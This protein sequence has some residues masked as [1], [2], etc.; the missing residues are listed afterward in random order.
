MRANPVRGYPGRT[1]R[2]YR[3]PVVF[4][5]GFGLSYTR[6]SQSL[7]QAPTKV[8]VPLSKH[9]TST[10]T[11]TLSNNAVRVLHTK[12]DTTTSLSLHIDV[13]NTGEADGSHTVLVF[14]SP[15]R[16]AQASEKHLIGFKKVHVLAGSLER[17]R[18]N[19]HVCKHLSTADEFGIRR[20]QMGEHTLHIG[21]DIKHQLSLQVDLG[22]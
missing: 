6:F 19:I 17:V 5:F 4:P 21:D 2:F 8:M 18:M 14:S 7:A 1:Y 11:T 3:G 20:I 9:Y 16:G 13:K 15:P 22:N 10:N 12:C